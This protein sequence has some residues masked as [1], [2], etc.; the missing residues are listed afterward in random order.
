MNKKFYQRLGEIFHDDYVFC[1]LFIVTLLESMN[2]D[3]VYFL[4]AFTILSYRLI[5]IRS[6][7]DS[8]LRTLIVFS[9]TYVGV[10]IF[11]G[12]IQS[13]F[14]LGCY[15]LSPTIFYAIGKHFTR[16]LT[17]DDTLAC[18]IIMTFLL[19]CASLY[20]D[21][22]IDVVEIG[23]YNPLRTVGDSEDSDYSSATVIGSMCVFGISCIS[24]F[25]YAQNKL[26]SPNRIF[27]FTAAFLSLLTTM[28]LLNR[29]GLYILIICIAFVF[30]YRNRSGGRSIV[31]MIG[32]LLLSVFIIENLGLISDD[33]VE[34]YQLRD[35]FDESRSATV[36]GRGEHWSESI[37]F[38]FTKPFGWDAHVYG[39]SHNLW[40]DVARVS[41]IFPLLILL[42]FSVKVFSYYK[43]LF[44]SELETIRCFVL[45]SVFCIT[46]QAS[47]EPLIECSQ[48]SFF[49]FCMMIGVLVEIVDKKILK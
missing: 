33:L 5:G 35:E 32:M 16:K 24:Y 37:G 22:I 38:V 42:V 4:F 31:P 18:F 43:K 7:N 19:F 49:L 10:I 29:S 44:R 15:L 40:L 6:Y 11:K 45:S 9:F 23:I 8:I 48:M 36:G 21:I 17:D 46:I 47:I 2:H 30:I 41:G 34:Q 26:L 39:Y 14:N 3:H 20:F 1:L 28:H 25:L 27:A 12:G 13:W